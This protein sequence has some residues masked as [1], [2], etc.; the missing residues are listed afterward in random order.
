MKKICKKV[1]GATLIAVLLASFNM[2]LAVSQTDINNQK[3]QQQENNNK[4]KETEQKKEEVK[5]IKDETLKEVEQLNSQITDYQGQIASLD[6]EI[7]DANAKIKEQETKLAQAE[8]DYQEQQDTLEKRIVAVYESGETSYLDVL[9]SS[10]GLTD[11]IS[12]YYLVSEVTQYDTEMLQEIQKQ[13][14]EIENAKKE[15]ENSKNELTTAKGSVIACEKKINEVLAFFA[16][17]SQKCFELLP[18]LFN[19][20]FVQATDHGAV[21]G[22]LGGVAKLLDALCVDKM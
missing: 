9:L 6:A 5:E 20:D 8:N 15:I 16:E 22:K 1:L 21:S 10:E 19:R 2:S 4:I 11:F 3:S 17:G 18:V 13:K 12:N 14:E 7:S